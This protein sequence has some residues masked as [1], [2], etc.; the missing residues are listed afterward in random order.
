MFKKM[1]LLTKTGIVILGF[2]GDNPT[3]SFYEKEIAKET[4]L[5]TGAVNNYMRR[6]RSRGVVTYEKRGKT[7]LYTIN[8]DSFLARELKALLN[9]IRLEEFIKEV[10]NISKRI[11][12]FGSVAQGTDLE[13]SDVD[14]F[15]LSSESKDKFSKA[16]AKAES[17]IHKKINLIIVS[18]AE[19]TRLREEPIYKNIQKGK[20]L[21]NETR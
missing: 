21:W 3:K 2:L 17:R 9:V 18:P 6:F 16:I 1:D 20:V 4:R 10:K 19:L 7:S 14:I 11:T 5:S 15:I 8:L 12:L 13:E